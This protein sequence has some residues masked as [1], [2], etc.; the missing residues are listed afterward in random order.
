MEHRHER[1]RRFQPIV[2]RDLQAF[3]GTCVG[4]LVAFVF[5][6]MLAA[7]AYGAYLLLG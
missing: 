6:V 7:M 3:H 2:N 5:W 1:N 4:L